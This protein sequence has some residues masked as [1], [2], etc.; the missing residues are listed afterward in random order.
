MLDDAKTQIPG[1]GAPARPKTMTTWSTPETAEQKRYY[2]KRKSKLRAYEVVAA[3]IQLVWAYY[4]FPAYKYLLDGAYKEFAPTLLWTTPYVAGLL[5]L[6]MHY[7]LRETYTTYWFDK[8]DDNEETDS[9]I[10]IPIILILV[11]FVAGRWG[12]KMAFEAQIPAPVE[13]TYDQADQVLDTRSTRLREQYER[14]TAATESTF[15]GRIAAAT[16]TID[17]RIQALRR[18]RPATYEERLK[19]NGEISALQQRRAAV[20]APIEQAKSDTLVAMLSRYTAAQQAEDRQHHQ[21]VA[22]VDATNADA[23]REHSDTM[24]HIGWGSW[25]LSLFFVFIY[26]ALGRAI[27]SIKVK[28]GILPQRDHTVLDQY[29]GTIGRILYV[30]QDIFNRQFYRFSLFVHRLGT[31]GTGTLAHMD[32]SYQETQADYNSKA[33]PPSGP[34]IP[35]K[36]QEQAAEEV[37]IKMARH[38][39]VKLS[40]DDIEREVNLAMY[41]NGN[42][43]DLPLQ[44]GKKHEAPAAP[45]AQAAGATRPEPAPLPS[46]DEDL[47]Y[48]KGSVQAQLEAH[49]R[50]FKAGEKNRA[51]AIQDYVFTDP[52]SPIVKH[53]KRLRLEW[54]VQHGEF[55]VRHLD[56]QHF[57]PLA[58]ISQAAL[59][60][61]SPAPYAAPDDDDLFKQNIDLFKQKIQPHTD[62]A[63]KVIGIKYLKKDQTWTTYDYNTVRG[64]WGIYL[65]RSK[66]GEVSE[67]VQ[68]GLEKWQYAM[69]LFEEGRRELRDNLQPITA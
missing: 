65:S 42:Y 7:I 45:Q 12:V 55:K 21:A 8:L 17:T 2:S 18:R 43:P 22:K 6:V 27:V 30:F 11:L 62:E 10:M 37:L 69:S 50:H 39:E 54:G 25:L 51:A 64:Q 34:V 29:G 31:A 16:L 56:R 41:M 24:S 66:R 53:G 14:N 36:T 5:L 67:A 59:L 47:Q 63:G 4:D 46:Y 68:A 23:A 60:A 19:I 26:C 48:W 35:L 13:H 3:I 61:P 9:S 32:A 40:K 49:D 20:A 28:S 44:G 15:N 1:H 57:V 38:P 58:E 33:L 52:H